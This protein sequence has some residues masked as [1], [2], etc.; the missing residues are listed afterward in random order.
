MLTITPNTVADLYRG[1][2]DPPTIGDTPDEVNLP[3]QQWPP[4]LAYNAD[5]LN[6]G[7]HPPSFLVERGLIMSTTPLVRTNGTLADYLVI[8]PEGIAATIKIL[9][10]HPRMRNGILFVSI[11]FGKPVLSY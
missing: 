9:E 2:A 10:A 3:V 4:F 6:F 7:A 1:R 11:Y 8:D 5:Q